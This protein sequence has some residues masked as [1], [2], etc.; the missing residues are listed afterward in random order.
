[1]ILKELTIRGFGKIHHYHI[2][3]GDHLNIIYG[4]NEAGKS[5][6]HAFLRAMLYGLER[7]RGRAARNDL[8]SRY[9]PWFGDGAYGGSLR[10]EAQG[11]LYRI[12]RDFRK[13]P[14]DLSVTNESSGTP[15]ENPQ[16]FMQQLLGNLSETAY[17]NTV[18]IQQLKSATDDGMVSELKNYI[19]NMNTSGNRALN[20]SKASAFLKEQRKGFEKQLLPDVTKKYTA[21]LSEIRKIEDFISAPE[22]KNQIRALTSSRDETKKLQSELQ[23]KKEALLQRLSAE[24]QTLLDKHF[25]GRE[26]ILAFRERL[27]A[28]FQQ[29]QS[30]A[31]RSAAAGFR[32]G[33]ISFA[34][35]ALLLVIAALLASKNNTILYTPLALP[36]SALLDAAAAISALIALL[37]YCTDKQRKK[38]CSAAHGALQTLIQEHFHLASETATD[39]SP[40]S[41]PEKAET[42]RDT[43]NAQI[44]SLLQSCAQ[45]EQHEKTVTQISE[46]L[47]QLSKLQ[48]QTDAAISG[49]QKNQWLLEQQL[50]LLSQRRAEAAGLKNLVAENERLRGEIEAITLAQDT[51]TRLSTTIRDSFGLYLNQRSSELIRGVTG[52]IYSSLSIDQNLNVY[53]NTSEKLIPLEQVS[54]GTMDQVYLALRLAAAELMQKGSFH[55]PLLFDDSFVNY[56]EERLRTVL[57]WLPVAFPDMQVL[58]FTCHRREAQLLSSSMTE[59]QL[60]EL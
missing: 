18:S 49:Q 41:E 31:Q 9:E 35:T 25:S 38:Y 12:E 13:N 26:D 59:Y 32:I 47:A 57:S 55:L 8:F 2:A 16:L 53:L 39:T 48:N 43:L 3:F 24:Q 4:G 54:A 33:A 28:A 19:A 14:L 30:A 27:D 1:M 15:V 7:A 36:L 17:A 21:T 60:I 40:A 58:I 20:I 34:L 29:Y 5:T 42:I 6:L 11:Q 22:N 37:L 44:D 45:T 52:G 10:L 51:M 23:G 46:R 56:D 50:E